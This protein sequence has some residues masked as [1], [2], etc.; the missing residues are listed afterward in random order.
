MQREQRSIDVRC[1]WRSHAPGRPV[2]GG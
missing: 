2:R 1:D